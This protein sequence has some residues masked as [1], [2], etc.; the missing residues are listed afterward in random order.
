MALAAN[1]I[2]PLQ[3][4]PA[5]WL[6]EASFW[7][8]LASVLTAVAGAVGI[9]AIVAGLRE[10]RG[11]IKR[12]DALQEIDHK[13]ARLVADREDLDLRRIEHVLLDLRDTQRRLEDALLRAFEARSL[14]SPSGRELATVPLPESIGERVVNR[15]LSLGY[16]QV[17][18]VTRFEKLA[19]L[20]RSDGEVLVEAKREGVLH[21]GRVSLRLGR[22]ADVEMTPAY[23]IF[24]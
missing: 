16:E 15:L 18:I 19:E 21:K 22:L 6:A 11:G 12:L 3:A 17:E 23:S 14:P 24:P 5:P 20:A 9:W 4:T 1:F 13:L 2:A 10:L 8:A 7:L